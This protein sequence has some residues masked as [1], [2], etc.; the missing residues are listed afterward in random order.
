V[1]KKLFSIVISVFCCSISNASDLKELVSSAGINFLFIKDSSSNLVHMKI[2][3]RNA[4]SAHQE[5][6]KVGLPLFYSTTVFCGTG[7]YS[8][9]KF[10]EACQDLSANILCKS[11]MDNFYFSL[12]APTTVL[13]QSATL[14]NIAI[15]SPN[16][17]EDKVK[18]IQ[19]SVMCFIQNHAANPE[20]IASS[21]ILPSIIFKLHD[22]ESGEFGYPEDFMKLSIKD[23]KNYKAIFLVTSNAEVCVYGNISEA[24]AIALVDQVFSGIEK[25]T[26]SEDKIKDVTLQQ[27]SETKKYYADGPQSSVFFVLKTERPLSA[28]RYAALLLYRILGE[29]GAFKARI[30]SR[31]RTEKGLI[32]SGGV[33]TIDLN[34]ASYIFGSLKTDNSKVQSTIE[35][36]KVILK[37]LREKGINESELQFAKNNIK[38]SMLVKLR[39]SDAICSFYFNRKLQGLGT[40]MLSDTIEKIDKVSLKE[41]NAIANEI[42]DENNMLFLVIGGGEK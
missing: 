42:L 40:M 19:N 16:F 33:S 41:V 17:E 7:A 15:K 20:Q 32:Y 2:A 34:H 21:S 3:F 13:K 38:G 1:N 11:D 37:E 39:T 9:D 29:G 35:L 6:S 25:R 24:E 5:K 23:L 10:A 31:L 18:I 14:F 4:G 26:K 27:K 30:L 36:L 12:T 8:K 28:K 22:Y